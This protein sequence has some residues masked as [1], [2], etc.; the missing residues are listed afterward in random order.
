M[1]LFWFD[2]TSELKEKF[3][4]IY[5]AH[6]P[7]FG[8]CKGVDGCIN[9]DIEALRMISNV[10]YNRYNNGSF[11]KDRLV[12]DYKKKGIKSPADNLMN[13]YV[14]DELLE[15]VVKDLIKWCWERNATREDKYKLLSWKRKR[16]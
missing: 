8:E 9:N 1:V 10:Y 4:I 5:D 2:T 7:S 6:I 13:R 14:N 16:V 15:R 3:D 12:R 11:N